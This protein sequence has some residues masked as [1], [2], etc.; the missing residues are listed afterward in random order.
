MGIL[1]DCFY[2]H[3]RTLA[4]RHRPAIRVEVVLQV[5]RTENAAD[6]ALAVAS[7]LVNPA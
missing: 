5:T 3:R 7:E 1:S 6:A 4:R 2:Q